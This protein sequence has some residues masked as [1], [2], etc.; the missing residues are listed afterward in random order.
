MITIYHNPR[1]TKSRQGVAHLNDSGKDFETIL[2]LDNPIDKDALKSL[3]KKLNYAPIELVR[4]NEA[5]WKEQ[6]KGKELNDE[7]II[8]AMIEFPKLME[9][10]IIVNGSKAVVGRPTEAIDKVL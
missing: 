2:Y 7:Q 3:L 4:K 6:F 9:R 8:D 1:C 10:P 5:I